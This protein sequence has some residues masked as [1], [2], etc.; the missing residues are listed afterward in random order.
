MT[1]NW[2]IPAGRD[3]KL[4]YARSAQQHFDGRFPTIAELREFLE[5]NAERE[6]DRGCYYD[7]AMGNCAGGP[8]SEGY[9]SDI[10]K[11]APPWFRAFERATGPR[12]HWTGAALLPVLDKVAAA[13]P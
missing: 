13:F 4:A 12:G 3:G 9:A 6:F 10:D 7:C 8:V 1:R 5:A 2:K 11:D